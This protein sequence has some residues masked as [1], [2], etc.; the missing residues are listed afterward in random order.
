MNSYSLTSVW[1][2]FAFDN[3]EKVK[4]GH[5]ALYF[6]CIEL[7]NSLGWKEKFGLPTQHTMDVLGIKNYK[8]YSNHLHDLV[9]FGFINFV[10][11]S[12]NQYTSNI[13][14]L[15]KNTKALPKAYTK[16]LSKHIP[17]Q[18]QSTVSIDKLI[19]N[20]L[21][22]NKQGFASHEFFK[23]EEFNIFWTEFLNT[24]KRKKASLNE[25]ILE[26]QFNKLLKISNQKYDAALSVLTK[27]VNSGWIDFYESKKEEINNHPPSPIIKKFVSENEI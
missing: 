21:I 2:Q 10:Q 4:P 13:I 3:P 26:K 25:K 20:K 27:S 23:K 24:K 6:W 9:D 19:N 18:V 1:F 12:K 17:K 16:A 22:N 14:A 11:L 8:T 5:H 7:C 15:V